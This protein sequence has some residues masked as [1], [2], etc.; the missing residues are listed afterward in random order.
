MMLSAILFF[1]IF[2]DDF[3]I[4]IDTEELVRECL[5]N[6]DPRKT[7]LIPFDCSSIWGAIDVKMLSSI[8]MKIYLLRR[9]NN[10]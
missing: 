3:W 1:F 2:V 8:S 5:V 9:V 4:G 10:L 7:Q 6:F